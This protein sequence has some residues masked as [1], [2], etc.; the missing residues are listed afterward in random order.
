MKSSLIVFLS[1]LGSMSAN[2]SNANLDKTVYTCS[3]LG[4]DNGAP[5]G[6]PRLS[7]VQRLGEG[8]SYFIKLSPLR[9]VAKYQK[10][11]L[12]KAHVELFLYNTTGYT[13]HLFRARGKSLAT[14]ESKKNSLKAACERVD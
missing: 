14:I 8:D 6:G 9:G 1:L 12:K 10:M 11:T 3:R 4:D 7:I 2:A 5:V 13:V